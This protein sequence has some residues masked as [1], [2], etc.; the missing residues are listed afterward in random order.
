[1]NPDSV[2]VQKMSAFT[3]G[4]EGGNPAG[5]V[6]TER[7]PPKSTMQR[8]AAEVGAS[9]TVFAA[10]LGSAWRVRYF[11]PETEI[12]F[13]GHA[14]IAL[15]A[16]LGER[17][18][19]GDYDLTLN[20]ASIRVSVTAQLPGLEASLNSPPT[21]SSIAPAS[22]VDGVLALFGYSRADL[23]HRLAPARAHAGANHLI[24]FL[25]SRSALAAM[26]YNL[27]RGRMFMRANDLVTI[28][29]VYSENSQFFHAR[30]AFASGGVL[31][32]PATGAAAAA[33]AG[34]LRDSGWPH[35]G[36]IEITQGED[37][38]SRSRLRV[39]LTDVRGSSVRVVGCA[40]HLS[41]P[42]PYRAL[43][44]LTE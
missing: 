31:E 28:A 36:K 20:E 1:M 5:I 8:I 3:D 16:A 22:L 17:H 26:S 43:T 42:E 7:L 19:L 32:D 39:E 23:D 9:E 27:D 10:P 11:S 2:L 37:M 34:Y 41:G 30:N 13:C 33:L 4:D 14:T 44:A 18:G 21:T 29:F 6:I 15:A 24:V 40:R 38:G 12:P 35:R 25:S